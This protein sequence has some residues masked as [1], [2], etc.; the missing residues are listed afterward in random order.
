M[1]LLAIYTLVGPLGITVATVLISKCFTKIGQQDAAAAGAT[2][3]VGY[4]LLQLTALANYLAFSTSSDTIPC[5]LEGMSRVG[6]V[7][8]KK[9]APF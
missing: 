9:D 6:A 5:G 4:G 1:K 2:F 3:T 8:G 7:T